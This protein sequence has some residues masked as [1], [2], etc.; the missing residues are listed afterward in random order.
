M[1][2]FKHDIAKKKFGS[3]AG[4]VAI[5]KKYLKIIASKINKKTLVKIY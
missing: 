4:C 1:T 3:T 2:K 5:K